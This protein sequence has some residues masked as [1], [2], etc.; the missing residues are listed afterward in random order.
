VNLTAGQRAEHRR[1]TGDLA[2]IGLVLPGSLFSA[3]IS[4]GTRTCRCQ[5]TPPALH[6]PYWRWTRKV[7]GKTVTRR[8]TDDQQ[9][10][11]QPLV[12]N[13]RRLRALVAELEALTLD[14]V[15]QDHRR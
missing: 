15:G 10:D 7:N 6:G 1:I 11:Y 3:E 4:C 13:A 12:D 9:R 2:R 14:V 5:G 8:L